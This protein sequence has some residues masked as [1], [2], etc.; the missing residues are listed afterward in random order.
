MSLEMD[1]IF[2]DFKKKMVHDFNCKTKQLDYVH[3]ESNSS[4]DSVNLATPQNSKPQLFA[5]F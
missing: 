2:V 3:T 4:S 1:V 5:H